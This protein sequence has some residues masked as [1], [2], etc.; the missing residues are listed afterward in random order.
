M[1]AESTASHAGREEPSRDLTDL[2]LLGAAIASLIA[3]GRCCSEPAV[4]A[5]T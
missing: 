3:V 4:P 2:A 1:D 5:G